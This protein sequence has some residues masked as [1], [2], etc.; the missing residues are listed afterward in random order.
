MVVKSLGSLISRY[1]L[2][3][4]CTLFLTSIISTLTYPQVSFAA[5][6]KVTS[7]ASKPKKVKSSDKIIEMPSNSGKMISCI[8][9]GKIIVPAKL[10]KNRKQYTP[11]GSE[12]KI[13]IAAL[14]QKSKLAK[15]K[16]QQNKFK[17]MAT[18]MQ[19]ELKTINSSCSLAFN[20]SIQAESREFNLRENDDRDFDIPV[21]SSCERALSFKILDKSGN[22]SLLQSSATQFRYSAGF[23]S[24]VDVI[25]FQAC[26][27]GLN[28]CSNAASLKFFITAGER[29]GK[30]D[31][32]AP[33]KN[34]ISRSEA[35]HLIKKIALNDHFVLTDDLKQGD[36]YNLEA[37]INKLL[38]PNYVAPDLKL[39]LEQMR[40]IRKRAIT[41]PLSYKGLRDI[42]G[43]II[44]PDTQKFDTNT[45]Q[46]AGIEK[47]IANYGRGYDPGA[48]W[49]SY[50]GD[51]SATIPIIRSRY[52]S[53]LVE[54]MTSM[55]YGHFGTAMHNLGYSS[56]YLVR[57]YVNLV[58]DN[59]IGN[60]KQLMLGTSNQ[61]CISGVGQGI[62][63]DGASN[64]WL[65]NVYNSYTSPN[66]N[67]AREL[68]ELYLLGPKDLYTGQPNYTEDD[69][70][71]ATTFASGYKLQS[72]ASTREA[73]P[74]PSLAT[75]RWK[76]A[77]DPALHDF[78]D[79]TA[80][81]NTAY[82]FKGSHTV[83]EFA[84]HIIDKHPGSARFIAG[85]IFRMLAYPDP[86]EQLVQELAE[87]F[88][89][90]NYDI[91]SLIHKIAGSQAMFS[92]KGSEPK[93][94]K[95]P[96]KVFIETFR[97]L[98]ISLFPSSQFWDTP[99]NHAGYIAGLTPGYYGTFVLFYQVLKEAG[100][101]QLLYDSVFTHDYCGR[102]PE[103]FGQRWTFSVYMMNR[104]KGMI[105][106]VVQHGWIHDGEFRYYGLDKV[107]LKPGESNLALTPSRL[108]SFFNDI[109]NVELSTEEYATM[110]R[111]ITSRLNSDYSQEVSI[112]WNPLDL[113]LLEEKLAGLIVIY[114]SMSQ[115]NVS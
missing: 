104:I 95:E 17:E 35:K 88:K 22:G 57:D 71:S 5:A 103:S 13:K 108:I 42:I 14:K 113:G 68:L 31:S 45:E 30:S 112:G 64:Y 9:A 32:L 53:P 10:S 16:K 38:D 11:L 86:S 58:H 90:N 4:C 66:Q 28:K 74:N 92:A 96:Y 34:L 49:L 7:G 85:K 43:N 115:S 40:D 109:Y 48:Q 101:K 84:E 27:D 79:S 26:V 39:H 8:Q 46:I 44:F 18:A 97:N 94:I 78:K 37:I 69:I 102:S 100:E 1:A 75:E 107:I 62:V 105:K 19:E 33:Y 3:A 89:A 93:C 70:I 114:S 29:S 23:Y 15:S 63:C 55:W 110:E 61:S 99:V 67:F 47:I 51:N 77:Y 54:Q 25:T 24:S 72:Y 60:F 52:L 2:V 21:T 80:F 50:G 73:A 106:L 12:Y 41:D 59:A 91:S 83:N 65:S 82:E 76:V 111:Y 98:K 6:G 81:A 36:Q 56:E 87:Y 20:C